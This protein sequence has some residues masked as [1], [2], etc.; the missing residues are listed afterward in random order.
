M[1][2][3]ALIYSSKPLDMNIYVE[4]KSGKERERL[5][6]E[7]VVSILNCKKLIKVIAVII[8]ETHLWV[9]N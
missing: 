4:G 3:T 5:T 1:R 9:F 7:K 2:S 6:T 8:K